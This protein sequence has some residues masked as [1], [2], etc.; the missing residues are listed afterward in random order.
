M[1]FWNHFSGLPNDSFDKTAMITRCIL[2]TWPLL[3]GT[4]VVVS[5]VSIFPELQCALNA[6]AVN[7]VPRS[8]KIRLGFPNA[9]VTTVSL[10]TASAAVVVLVRNIQTN[11]VNA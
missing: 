4:P 3:L 1:T 2:S 10:F 6:S 8:V 7:A 11:F 5:T 9:F